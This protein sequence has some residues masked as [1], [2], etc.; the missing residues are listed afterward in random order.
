MQLRRPRNRDDPRL[1]REQPG[2]RDLGFVVIVDL[3][4]GGRTPIGVESLCA[5]AAN[6]N[7]MRVARAASADAIRLRLAVIS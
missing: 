4:P 7:A 6:V 3:G 1:L 2:E 5:A